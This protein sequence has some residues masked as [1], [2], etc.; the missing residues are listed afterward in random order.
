MLFRSPELNQTNQERLVTVYQ[1]RNNEE[2]FDFTLDESRQKMLDGL[3][4]FPSYSL[5]PLTVLQQNNFPD[6]FGHFDNEGLKN[7]GPWAIRD[8]QGAGN[9]FYLGGTALFETIEGVLGVNDHVEQV[10]NSSL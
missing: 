6:Y 5:A 10:I 7:Y 4:T 8:M 1:C 3:A 2:G 9:T